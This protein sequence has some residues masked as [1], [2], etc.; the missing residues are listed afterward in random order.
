[1]S[2]LRVIFD[3]DDTLYPERDFAVAG[4]QA[5]GAW[6]EQALGI[7]GL[8]D[9]M[10]RLL[11]EGHLGQ[12]F[13]MALAAKKPDHTADDLAGLRKAYRHNQPKLALYP[14]AE[15][16]LDH[17]GALGPIGL[18]TDGT[19]AMQESKVAGLGIAPRF[20]EIVYTDA[21]GPDRAFFKPHPRAFEVIAG[22]MGRP[23]D[24]FVYVGDNLAKDFV[25]PNALGWTTVWIERPLRIH[26]SATVKPG[27]EPQHRITS[28]E[29][30][31]RL[32]LR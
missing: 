29:D 5:A 24:R 11:D 12:L 9:D 23:G 31:A 17:F 3:L 15:M 1:M 28:L 22:R 30:L 6:A 20:A 2:G 10:T 7:T 27:G 14:D 25:A 13:A 19:L 32:A 8:G 26:T 16:A 21:L 18:I 4:F